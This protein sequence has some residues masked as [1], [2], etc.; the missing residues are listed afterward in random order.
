[1]VK[2]LPLRGQVL[3]Q[4][5]ERQGQAESYKVEGLTHGIAP[6]ALQVESIGQE[7]Q[8]E[9]QDQP[10]WRLFCLLA[11][12]GPE[13]DGSEG[14]H[15]GAAEELSEQGQSSTEACCQ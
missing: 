15:D 10:T 9:A 7:G 6:V 12:A 14:G 3:E 5:G 11:H 8:Q 2:A 13:P 1:M 4:G